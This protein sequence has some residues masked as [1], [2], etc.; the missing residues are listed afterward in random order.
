MPNDNNISVEEYNK[1][2]VFF[3]SKTKLF[4][5]HINTKVEHKFRKFWLFLKTKSYLDSQAEFFIC[6]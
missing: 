5:K 2:K 3:D 4:Y 1:T 6:A